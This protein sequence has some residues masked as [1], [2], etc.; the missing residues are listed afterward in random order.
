MVFA[1]FNILVMASGAIQE[2]RVLS[3][4]GT[5]EYI[6]SATPTPTPT[7][8][9]VP[10]P[11]TSLPLTGLGGDYLVH[12]GD[13]SPEVWISET[14]IEMLAENR[15]KGYHTS[16][17]GFE[18]GDGTCHS[19]LDYEKFD[20]V[21]EIFD[22]VNIDVIP[23][24]WDD[25][26]CN[27]EFL[28]TYKAD[29]LNFVSYYKGDSRIVAVSI[30]CE[31]T[32][33]ILTE[34]SRFELTKYSAELTKEIHLVDPDRIVIFPFPA[35]IYGTFAEWY[36][37]LQQTEILSEPNVVFDVV[38]PYYFEND[39]DMGLTPEAKAVWYGKGWISPSV[40]FFGA[41][42]VFAGET[43]AGTAPIV[44][45]SPEP[46]PELQVRFLT[47]IINEYV[48]YD[49]GFSIWAVLGNGPKFY[50]N[51]LGWLASDY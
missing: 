8:I 25:Q 45:D 44:W 40:N 13:Q 27:S 3:A 46:T 41:N 48:E 47:A 6:F 51:E 34:L 11:V 17:L 23:V 1:T 49:I 43:F 42:R 2:T 20:R 18:F 33:S 35:L 50:L 38:H 26:T 15:D 21:L 37:D 36:A 16:K 22:S 30:F 5:I 29:W 12:F 32:N 28:N 7:L 10:T 31:Q 14:W 9:P 39:W 19:T 24:A 4:S